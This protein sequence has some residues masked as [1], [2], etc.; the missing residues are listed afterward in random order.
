MVSR[1]LS[2]RQQSLIA[3]RIKIL[4]K[5]LFSPGE[6]E[7]LLHDPQT[8]NPRRMGSGRMYR[9]RKR[10]FAK[11]ERKL[12]E[13][14]AEGISEKEAKEEMWRRMRGEEDLVDDVDKFRKKYPRGRQTSQ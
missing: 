1:E 11:R 7:F 14:I 6:I 5:E 4:E 2:R 10:E 3:R 13:I 8:G 12:D 9:F